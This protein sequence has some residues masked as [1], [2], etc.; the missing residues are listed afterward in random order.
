MILGELNSHE[1]QNKPPDSSSKDSELILKKIRG[2]NL[3]GSVRV[4]DF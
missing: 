1:Q 2:R 4:W 3:Y